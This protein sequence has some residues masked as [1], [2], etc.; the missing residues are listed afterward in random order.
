[1]RFLTLCG[2]LAVQGGPI[3]WVA[4]HRLHHAHSDREKDPHNSS[5]GFWWAHIGWIFYRDPGLVQ[6]E[7]YKHYA[8]DLVSDPFI[9][10]L[11]RYYVHLQFAL[12]LILLSL[13]GWSFVIWGTFVRLVLAGQQLG[14]HREE[15]LVQPSASITLFPVS[16][17]PV[18]MTMSTWS[19]SA[20]PVSPPP[21]ATWNTPSGMPH[22]AI[23]WAI[24][25]EVSGV[26]SEGLRTTAL[27]AASAGMQSPN[28]LLSG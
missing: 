10:F 1:M 9:L 11:D 16:T 27:P 13:G 14:L 26:T 15:H 3:A 25:S 18:N 5:K 12:G 20:A 8:K 19:T 22:S 24:S 2:A 4:G 7:D 6:F 21:V 28:E 23:I 17:E